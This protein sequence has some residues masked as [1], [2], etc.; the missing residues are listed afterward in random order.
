MA[1]QDRPE[2][3]F[4]PADPAEAFPDSTIRKV[5][6]EEWESY[7]YNNQRREVAQD[8]VANKVVWTNWSGWHN[9]DGEL[10]MFVTEVLDYDFVASDPNHYWLISN[11]DT[12]EQALLIHKAVVVNL[13]IKHGLL[14]KDGT[15]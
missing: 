1:L 7:Y 11:V 2:R 15:A 3:F 4:L 5:S 6:R 10:M 9:E 14:P 8:E 13:A 12:R